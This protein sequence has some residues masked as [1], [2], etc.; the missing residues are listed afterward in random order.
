MYQLIDEQGYEKDIFIT[1]TIYDSIYF[2]IRDDVKVVKWLNDTLIPIMEQDYM[3]D[4]ILP[5]SAELEIGP[6]WNTLFTLPH[7]ASLEKLREIRRKF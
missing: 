7:E 2:I 3:A 4:Q 6:D 5:N 1:S